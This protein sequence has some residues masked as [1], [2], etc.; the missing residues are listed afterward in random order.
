MAAE[1][2]MEADMFLP[3]VET[4][5]NVELGSLERVG[6]KRT[7]SLVLSDEWVI[8]VSCHKRKMREQGSILL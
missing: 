4:L 8:T 6:E 1:L 7:K 3:W 5:H 2:A